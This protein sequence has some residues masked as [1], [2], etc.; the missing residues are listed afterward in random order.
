MTTSPVQVSV[1]GYAAHG[2]LRQAGIQDRVR[3]LVGDLVRMA[4]GY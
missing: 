2:I 1:A 4:L 3:N